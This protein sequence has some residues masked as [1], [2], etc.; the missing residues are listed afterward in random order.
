MEKFDYM[1]KGKKIKNL[2]SVN[3]NSSYKKSSKKNN[4]INS[5]S[6]I[7]QKKFIKKLHQRNI[8]FNNKISILNANST[9]TSSLSS[10]TEKKYLT[11]TKYSKEFNNGIDYYFN[12]SF[13]GNNDL[14]KNVNISRP[15]L[16]Y[17][18]KNKK[19]KN[20]HLALGTEINRFNNI[21][22]LGNDYCNNNELIINRSFKFHKNKLVLWRKAEYSQNNS[23]NNEDEKDLN[24]KS[25][26]NYKIN[27]NLSDKID[28]FREEEST[29]N[30]K[31]NNRYSFIPEK[32]NE[33]KYKDNINPTKQKK[34]KNIVLRPHK[35]QKE[36]QLSNLIIFQGIDLKQNNIKVNRYKKE[37]S[38]E[39][40]KSIAEKMNVRPKHSRVFKYK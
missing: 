3:S 30:D 22:F 35:I 20:L 40:I 26:E 39:I 10:S 16:K 6:K 37:N 32:Y 25:L 19:N 29:K 5:A 24:S 1:K 13:N 15:K 11:P 27:K 9:S 7:K 14:L 8:L 28:N 36:K 21:Y 31:I 17:N 12:E 4:I 2:T 33:N 38:P 23:R 34:Y 18:F